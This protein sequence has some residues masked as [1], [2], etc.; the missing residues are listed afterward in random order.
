V[1]IALLII[2]DFITSALIGSAA[3]AVLIPAFAARDEKNALALLW[4]VLAVSILAFAV[5][6]LLIIWQRGPLG[7]MLDSDETVHKSG[8]ALAIALS[9][10]PLTAAT[11]VLTAWLQYRGRLVIPAFANVMFNCVILL[12]LWFAPTTLVVLAIGIVVASLVR[13]VTHWAAFSRGGVRV[14]QRRREWQLNPRLLRAYGATAGTGIFSLLPYYLPYALVAASG[15]GVALF[16]YAFKLVLLPGG[17]LQTMI[18]LILLPWLVR[19]KNAATP[20]ERERA[21]SLTLQAGWLVSFAMTLCLWLASY[22]LILLCYDY[23]KMT[24][25]DIHAMADIFAIGIWALP[26]IAMI[27]LWQQILYAH[28][29]TGMPLVASVVQALLIV[30]LGLLLEQHY[31]TAGIIMAYV[32]V[33]ILPVGMLAWRAWRHK[34]VSS[35]MPTVP[36]WIM[37]ALVLAAFVPMAGIY[38]SIH[39]GGLAGIA[40]A[41]VM[42]MTLLAC[43][44]FACAPLRQTIRQARR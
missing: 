2:P 20:A 27:A 23:G 43:G 44:I 4:Q 42:G 34:V 29:H 35:F 12:V 18:Q 38:R 13:I 26:G 33:Q 11:S 37:S 31:E 8:A 40:V 25:D 15:H 1:A 21:Y 22:P 14:S 39:W 9:S 30:P 36:T 41:M 16:N 28:E 6:A 10:L 19:V 7:H 32:I 24:S 17:L 3:S 5:L